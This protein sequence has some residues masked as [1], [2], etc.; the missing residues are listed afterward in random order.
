MTTTD[1]LPLLTAT[2]GA[3][4]GPSAD[5]ISD[6][7]LVFADPDG[8]GAWYLIDTEEEGDCLSLG[9]RLEAENSNFE[10]E[11][12]IPFDEVAKWIADG[13]PAFRAKCVAISTPMPTTTPTAHTPGPWAITETGIFAEHLNAHGNFYI[14]ALPFPREEPSAQEAANL[15]LIAAAPELLA[16][17]RGAE[18]AL[19]KALPF[20]PADAEAHFV[21]EWL[22]EARAA[23]AKAEGAK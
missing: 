22:E 3:N 19:R 2:F 9:Y 5:W 18:S 16:A 17:L 21:G 11:T 14:C 10:V 13:L 8:E 6:A 12:T 1:L 20:C 23:I 7:F 4:L 15:R